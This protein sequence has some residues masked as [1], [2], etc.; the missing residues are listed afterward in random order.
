MEAQII[1]IAGRV[2][3]F[4]ADPALF[5][6]ASLV[7]VALLSGAVGRLVLV[8]E[9]RGFV[10]AERGNEPRGVDAGPTRPSIG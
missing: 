5:V 3:A 10:T 8:V 9:A 2:G 1:S 6:A 7:V 4:V